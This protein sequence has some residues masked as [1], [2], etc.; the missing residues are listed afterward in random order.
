MSTALRKPLT[1]CSRSRRNS[2]AV[3]SSAPAPR[4]SAA[5]RSSNPAQYRLPPIAVHMRYPPTSSE[6]NESRPSGPPLE[7]R[8]HRATSTLPPCDRSRR[9]DPTATMRCSVERSGTT[10]RRLA[11]T[12]GGGSRPLRATSAVVPSARQTSHS[13]IPQ[14][15]VWNPGSLSSK[16]CAIAASAPS[17]QQSIARGSPVRG[18]CLQLL[19]L[20]PICTPTEECPLRRR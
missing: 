11:P 1:T 6:R 2:G 8:V 19:S 4:Q 15:T 3:Q 5:K 13:G 12:T 14:S 9:S 16:V 10:H 7:I 20:L 18:Q 17:C